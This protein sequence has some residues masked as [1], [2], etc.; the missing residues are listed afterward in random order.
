MIVPRVVNAI[1]R[2]KIEKPASI[3]GVQ[4][5]SLAAHVADVHLKHI[6]QTR[7]LRVYV[8]RIE[9]CARFY[10]NRCRGQAGLFTH[11]KN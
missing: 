9:V 4:L 6:Q 1:A 5:R 2:K 3:L 11:K 7:P 10:F 8:L